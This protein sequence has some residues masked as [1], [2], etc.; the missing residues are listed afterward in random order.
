VP[1]E[2]PKEPPEPFHGQKVRAL[3]PLKSPEMMARQCALRLSLVVHPLQH[4]IM[5]LR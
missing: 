3:D 2:L 4:L 5:S 1:D